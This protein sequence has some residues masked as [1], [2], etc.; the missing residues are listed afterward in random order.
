M[1]DT[2]EASAIMCSPVN[3]SPR[4]AGMTAVV[5]GASSGIGA[6]TAALLASHG[7]VVILFA[8][9]RDRLL[10]L[11]SRIRNGG[12]TALIAHGDIR[13]VSD[14]RALVASALTVS[15][16]IDLLI[17]AIGCGQR[18]PVEA[19][20]ID[21]VRDVFD[22]NVFAPLGLTQEVAVRMRAQ[23]S[24]RIINISSTS[25]RVARPFS[26][27]Y[28]ATKHALE[29]LSD[30][31]REELGPFG[32][33]TILIQP[34]YTTHS[35]FSAIADQSTYPSVDYASYSSRY[36]RS[37]WHRRWPTTPDAIAAVVLR[38]ATSRRPR[39]RYVVPLSA[40]ILLALR[41]LLPDRVFYRAI[42][43]VPRR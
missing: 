27:V 8:R 10:R 21:R 22:T 15:G 13:D 36:Q 28:D 7:C 6:A 14:R 12:G 18:G 23:G 2:S 11:A 32:V 34:G 3:A 17:N 25:G 33:H 4:L 35:E 9:R 31:L 41:L 38:A 29:A 16:R 26:A 5:T 30:G 40:R 37:T 24:G 20:P 42:L 1:T 19:V 39:T 43:R